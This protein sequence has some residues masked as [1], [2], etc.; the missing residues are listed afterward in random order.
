M[1]LRK[2]L[3]LVSLILLFLSSVYSVV[4]YPPT[5]EDEGR[6]SNDTIFV[7]VYDEGDNLVNC[8]I[9]FDGDNYNVAYEDGFCRLNITNFP[10]AVRDYTFQAFYNNSNNQLSERTFTYYPAYED[11]QDVSFLGLGS[12][13]FLFITL[14]GGFLYYRRK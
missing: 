2:S 10:T 7:I 9:L 3:I 6:Y 14:L 13:I 5:P 1:F 11:V 12:Y 8:N 4:Y